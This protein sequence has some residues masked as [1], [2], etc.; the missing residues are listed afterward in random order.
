MA[1]PS[2][3][4]AGLSLVADLPALL[5]VVLPLIQAIDWVHSAAATTL[6]SL[7]PLQIHQI[8]PVMA[9]MPA[10]AASVTQAAIEQVLESVELPQSYSGGSALVYAPEIAPLSLNIDTADL[11][12]D[13]ET[14]TEVTP[15]L[16][17]A[18]F[19]ENVENDIFGRELNV[20]STPL[21]TTAPGKGGPTTTNV[22][23]EGDPATTESIHTESVVASKPN[24]GQTNYHP[25]NPPTDTTG[26]VETFAVVDMGP[27]PAPK[28]DIVP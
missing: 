2:A 5:V 12:A 26:E 14:L 1:A 25:D 16:A 7:E 9:G 10:T 28:S 19:V 21:S 3:G 8:T 20:A 4:T 23:F 15:R 11:F 17:T 24:G 13:A 27:G 18:V 22:P 6:E